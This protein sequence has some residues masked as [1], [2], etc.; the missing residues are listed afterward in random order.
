[1]RRCVG[2]IESG[3]KLTGGCGLT[4][5]DVLNQ[6]RQRRDDEIADLE[7]NNL[8]KGEQLGFALRSGIAIEGD[9]GRL[10]NLSDGTIKF[11][12]LTIMT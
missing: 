9:Q 4:G 7:A 12:A 11:T 1:V 3:V 2:W 6:A 10:E 5:R 8:L